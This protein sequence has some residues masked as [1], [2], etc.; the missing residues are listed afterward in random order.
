MADEDIQRYKSPINLQE[1]SFYLR[2]EF[3]SLNWLLN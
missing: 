2:F 1:V 3:E